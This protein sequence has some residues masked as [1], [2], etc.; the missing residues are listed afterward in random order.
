MSSR[1]FLAKE[2]TYNAAITYNYIV[3]NYISNIPAVTRSS[4]A[5]HPEERE[6]ANVRAGMALVEI[7]RE[8]SA[9]V[10][11]SSDRRSAEGANGEKEDR[12]L[13][14]I[15]RSSSNASLFSCR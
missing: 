14:P 6:E 2:T 7:V 13:S 12:D 1:Y 15:Y 10:E 11:R 4:G 3:L 9:P 5:M 8:S